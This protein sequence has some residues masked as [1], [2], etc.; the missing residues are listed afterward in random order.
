M[1]VV[2]VVDREARFLAGMPLIAVVSSTVD[3]V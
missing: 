3:Q 2:V 1:L